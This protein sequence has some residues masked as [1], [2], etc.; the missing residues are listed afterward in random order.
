LPFLTPNIPKL[1]SRW[2][3]HA[4]RHLSV[5]VKLFYRIVSYGSLHDT[6]DT[7]GGVVGKEEDKS[8]QCESGKKKGQNGMI[9]RVSAVNA[10]HAKRVK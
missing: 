3:A 5:H 9:G 4:I 2:K 10:A 6:D 1:L 8:G 7:E